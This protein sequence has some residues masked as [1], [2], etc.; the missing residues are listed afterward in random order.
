MQEAGKEHMLRSYIPGRSLDEAVYED[1]KS[2]DPKDI[3]EGQEYVGKSFVDAFREKADELWAAGD[4]G[5]EAKEQFNAPKNTDNHK[6]LYEALKQCVK[7]VEDNIK[8][9]PRPAALDSLYDKLE[10]AW[11]KVNSLTDSYEDAEDESSSVKNVHVIELKEGE[12]AN[13]TFIN[14][15]NSLIPSG[16]YWILSDAWHEFWGGN[17]AENMDWVYKTLEECSDTLNSA[18]KTGNWESLNVLSEKIDK[19][20]GRIQEMRR[21]LENHLY[22]RPD[23]EKT[24]SPLQ[25]EG[26]HGQSKE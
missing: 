2:M 11:N 10:N 17:E 5:D 19:A 12:T 21:F 20:A 14:G 25:S 22:P 4:A 9:G 16:H 7:D 1:G 15:M 3:P 18:D 24:E 8:T 13:E 23:P 26:S 6:L